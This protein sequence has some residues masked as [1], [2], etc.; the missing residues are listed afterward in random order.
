MAIG[1]D[2]I[3][4]KV[5]SKKCR[6]SST[7]I[8]AQ[9][10]IAQASIDPS[11]H[12]TPYCM[13]VRSAQ[14]WFDSLVYSKSVH[15]S[16]IT[17]RM[18]LQ[19]KAS[20]C[21]FRARVYQ[22][23]TTMENNGEN[24]INQ[25]EAP[26]DETEACCLYL[27]SRTQRQTKSVPKI[28]EAIRQIPPYGHVAIFP[29]AGHSQTHPCRPGGQSPA[30]SSSTESTSLACVGLSKSSHDSPAHRATTLANRSVISMPLC[31][32]HLTTRLLPSVM[33]IKITFWTTSSQFTSS[34]FRCDVC[35]GY[36]TCVVDIKMLCRKL[37][38]EGKS[39]QIRRQHHQLLIAIK[40][41]DS[42]MNHTYRNHTFTAV[43][44]V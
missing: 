44:R 41:N 19:K 28:G 15:T 29:R 32:Y 18:G 30:W 34:Q 17:V 25:R 9:T 5:T 20:A 13:P 11:D 8:W 27:K 24:R 1:P 39:W 36:V 33:T 23:N 35:V 10:M 37:L 14:L 42:C 12:H 31:F 26:R 2:R 21:L 16:V 43:W 7:Q 22:A 4:R 6:H 40:W 38:N 3:A